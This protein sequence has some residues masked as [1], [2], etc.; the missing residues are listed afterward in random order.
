MSLPVLMGVQAYAQAAAAGLLPSPEPSYAMAANR[1]APM[2]ALDI[3]WRLIQLSAEADSSAAGDDWEQ[4]LTQLMRPAAY[5]PQPLDCLLSWQMLQVLQAIG[6]LRSAYQPS[7]KQVPWQVWQF[8]YI[9]PRGA[10]PCVL[11]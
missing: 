1:D 10:L 7:P 9:T 3:G 11:T 4:I 8:K 2:D 5:T 6:V